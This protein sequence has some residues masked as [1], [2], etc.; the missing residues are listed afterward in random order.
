MSKKGLRTGAAEVISKDGVKYAAIKVSSVSGDA[1][2]VLDICR[3]VNTEK[4]KKK[5]K[6]LQ[7]ADAPCLANRR[8]V[9]LVRPEKKMAGIGEVQEVISTMQNTPTAGYLRDLSLHERIMLAAVL[10]CVKRGGVEEVKW[11]DVSHSLS[12]VVRILR[13]LFLIFRSKTNTSYIQALW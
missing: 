4:K 3:Y 7:T 13:S 6:P 10:R 8:A 12:R 9:E 11:G 1:R 2:R 5:K